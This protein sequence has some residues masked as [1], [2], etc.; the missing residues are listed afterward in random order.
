VLHGASRKGKGE[1]RR[2]PWGNG[3][4]KRGSVQDLGWGINLDL[5]RKAKEMYER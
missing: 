5:K 3:L 1:D 4:L 2:R